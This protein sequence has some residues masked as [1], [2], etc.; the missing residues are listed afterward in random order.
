MADKKTI[1]QYIIKTLLFVGLCFVLVFNPVF[2][3]IPPGFRQIKSAEGVSLYKKSYSNKA[4]DFVQETSGKVYFKVG[5]YEPWGFN[6][7]IAYTEKDKTVSVPYT[8]DLA[9]YSGQYPK[10]FYVRYEPYDGGWAWVG[11]ITV[12]ENNN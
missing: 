12:V 9:K 1:K 8:H 6:R 3:E 4:P 2:A 10:E 11:P 5:T 7:K